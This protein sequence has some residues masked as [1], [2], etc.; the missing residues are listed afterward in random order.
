VERLA[1]K[2]PYARGKPKG[3]A[4]RNPVKAGLPALPVAPKARALTGLRWSGSGLPG[5]HGWDCPNFA[6][7][8]ARLRM[9]PIGT[10]MLQVLSCSVF[11]R[12]FWSFSC[13]SVHVTFTGLCTRPGRAK[14]S[15]LVSR[16]DDHAVPRFG[17]AVPGP[18]VRRPTR[19][20]KRISY[21]APGRSLLLSGYLRSFFGARVQTALPRA[22]PAKYESNISS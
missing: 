8:F 22:P 5:A 11:R 12:A 4:S 19:C 14:G 21:R 2:K 1:R 13:G 20:G 16:S 15:T 17:T 7:Q 3:R 10:L 18:S 6:N 9:V